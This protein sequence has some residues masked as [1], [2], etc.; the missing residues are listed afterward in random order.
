M[1]SDGI[2]ERLLEYKDN[3]IR[4][5]R[6]VK[7]KWNLFQIDTTD[8]E[9][10]LNPTLDK[11]AWTP[12]LLELSFSGEDYVIWGKDFESTI[13]TGNFKRFPK[14]YL[15][16]SIEIPIWRREEIICQYELSVDEGFIILYRSEED[17]PYRYGIFFSGPLFGT[18]SFLPRLMGEKSSLSIEGIEMKRNG[19]LRLFLSDL[20]GLLKVR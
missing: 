19:A 9:V 20:L 3:L 12:G 11:V 6:T 2:K 16:L 5:A 14:D 13:E 8:F 10:L 15:V 4:I 18:V 17:V 1:D 7:E